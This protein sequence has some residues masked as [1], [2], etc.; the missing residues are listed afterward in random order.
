MTVFEC[1]CPTPIGDQNRQNRQQHL[2]VATNIRLQ[3]RSNRFR[4]SVSRSSARWRS[5]RPNPTACI[6]HFEIPRS[7]NEL[8][9]GPCR[10]IILL[11][12]SIAF[13]I[14]SLIWFVWFS[15]YQI[16]EKISP[17][18]CWIVQFSLNGKFSVSMQFLMLTFWE[19]LGPFF[20]NSQP[21]NEPLRFRF[22]ILPFSKFDMN[23]LV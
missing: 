12:V 17:C 1:W 10:F 2:L 18:L 8:G 16:D 13:H 4:T 19:Q 9:S 5:I 23:F 20:D 14:F 15:T 22:L 7:K 11:H 6:R 3:H 21:M